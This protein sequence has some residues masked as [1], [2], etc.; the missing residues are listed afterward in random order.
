MNFEL[1][2][3]IL[4]GGVKPQASQAMSL[5][6]SQLHPVFMGEV[7]PISLQDTVDEVT[8]SEI[9]GG[10]DEYAV[11]VFRDQQFSDEEQMAF[12]KR[13]DGELGEL[14][15]GFSKG[16]HVKGQHNGALPA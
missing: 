1:F 10:L 11:L 16:G 12:A 6:I 5:S 4:A 7:G 15:A 2:R 8:L 9:R 3:S 13:L 14:V